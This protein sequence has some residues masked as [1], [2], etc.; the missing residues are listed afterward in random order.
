[1]TDIFT[2]RDAIARSAEWLATRGIDTPRLDA[3]LLLAH[4]L[5]CKRLDLFMAPDRPLDAEETDAYRA[6]IQRR[7]T[8]E[9]IAYILGEVGFWKHDFHI[10]SRALIPRPET[11]GILDV[12]LNAAGEQRDNALR[13]IDIGTGSGVLAISLALEFPNAHVVAIDVSTDA[14]ELT[15]ENAE[16]HGVQDRV[17]PVRSDLLERLIARGSKA[18]II[19]SNPPYVGENERE[20]MGQG[21]EQYEPYQALFSGPE[22]LDVIDRLLPQ[23]PQTLDVGG[24]FVM[25]FGSTQGDALRARAKRMFRRWRIQKDYSQHDRLLIVDAPGER[26]WS[27]LPAT[28]PHDESTSEETTNADAANAQYTTL[29]DPPFD[30]T[31]ARLDAMR[32]G[33]ADGAQPLPEID[34][35]A[36]LA[37]DDE[38]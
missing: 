13:I 7:A 37:P 11:E 24:L 36:D 12:V 5:D 33:G 27:L 26:T 35:H 38:S 31:R 23:I 20:I 14:L 4:T 6:L 16:R 3:E 8:H 22:G 17:H 34:L 19:V 10:D 32:Y 21:V 2:V 15:R 1:M 25:E 9:P 28:A 29:E 18:D 30:E